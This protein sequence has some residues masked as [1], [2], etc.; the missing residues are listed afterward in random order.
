MKVRRIFILVLIIIGAPCV[1]I[2]I[3]D[4]FFPDD[5]GWHVFF[6]VLC[7]GVGWHADRMANWIMRKIN[8]RIIGVKG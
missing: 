4:A 7:G 3:R 5:M 6:L 2:S 1:L 8:A